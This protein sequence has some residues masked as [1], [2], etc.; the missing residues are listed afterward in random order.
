MGFVDAG[1]HG[2]MGVIFT[3]LVPGVQRPSRVWTR[4]SLWPVS[5]PAAVSVFVCVGEWE[6]EGGSPGTVSK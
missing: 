2:Q 1:G 3:Q 6:A 4:W 5:S